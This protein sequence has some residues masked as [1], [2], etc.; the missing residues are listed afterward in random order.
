LLAG[1]GFGDLGDAGAGSQVLRSITCGRGKARAV[2]TV[3]KAVAVT[4]PTIVWVTDNVEAVGVAITQVEVVT[5]GLLAV[6][7]IGV[8]IKWIHHWSVAGAA[9]I[10]VA[11]EIGA[12]TVADRKGC[13]GVANQAD[14][15]VLAG[16]VARLVI[17]TA[18]TI[19]LF[20]ALVT[21]VVHPILG[22]VGADD[23]G[24]WIL[25]FAIAGFFAGGELLVAAALAAAG[26][27][28]ILAAAVDPGDFAV[29]A[30]G[31]VRFSNK[32]WA[33]TSVL[34]TFCFQVVLNILGKRLLVES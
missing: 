33:S 34:L 16:F 14:F 10:L 9:V 15:D 20:C 18:H 26:L 4:L 13:V 27:F 8:G 2:C 28:L 31:V 19:S 17:A 32:P 11:I 30:E 1:N 21:A 12:L 6:C 23:A 7:A 22:V 25:H 5:A 24:I 29:D 3:V